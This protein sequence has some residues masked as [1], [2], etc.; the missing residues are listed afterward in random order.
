MN[1]GRTLVAGTLGGLLHLV[2]VGGLHVY[3]Y[4]PEL[5]GYSTATNSFS[6]VEPTTIYIVFGAFVLGALPAVL[7][8][9][10][11]LVTPVLTILAFVAAIVLM[12][13]QGLEPQWK[14]AGPPSDLTFYFHLWFVPLL[15]ACV[16]GGIEELV[17]HLW[18]RE[19]SEDAPSVG[20]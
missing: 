12:L 2:L 14:A 16:L 13:P 19:P 15:V 10:R 9:E 4:G 3:L 7:L 6:R 8:A 5:F 20:E 18:R 17:R 11:R 1:T